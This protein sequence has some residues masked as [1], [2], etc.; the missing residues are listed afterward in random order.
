MQQHTSHPLFRTCAF[1][2]ACGLSVLVSERSRAAADPGD[3][4]GD[5]YGGVSLHADFAAAGLSSL[6]AG[7][8]EL[9]ADG[10]LSMNDLEIAGAGV[11]G[12]DFDPNRSGFDPDSKTLVRLYRWGGIR[13]IYRGNDQKLDID[14]SISNTSSKPLT[15]L[16]ITLMRLTFPAVPDG[17][18]WTNGY[19]ISCDRS[20][21]IPVLLADWHSARLA[22]CCSDPN[23][24]AKFGFKPQGGKPGDKPY[25]LWVK[26]DGAPIGP[27]ATGETKISLRIGGAAVAGENAFDIARDVLR[28]YAEKYHLE[29]AWNDR[30]P[31]GSAFLA[32]SQKDYPKNPRGW[33]LDPDID[34]TTPE[35]RAQFKIKMLAYAD[36]V[37]AH[38]KMMD[39]Q[40]VIVWDLEGQEMPHAT[41]Y[42]A[43]PRMLAKVAPEMDEI[44][45]E[46]MKKFSD[47]GL[48]TGLTIRPT[49]VA[50]ADQGRPGWMQ[51]D[52]SDQ[53]AEID[54]K[55]TYA[56]KRWGCTLFYLDS[57]V[58][59]VK[60]STGK[61]LSDPAMPAADFQKLARL[62]EDC[63]LMPEH[64]VG[65]YW[66]YTAPY[67]EF[68]LGFAS[69]PPG[70]R[71]AYPHAF[72]VLRVVDGPSLSDPDSISKL[73]AAVK[74][75]D[76]LLFRP[77]WDDPQTTDI[78][79]IYDVT[80]NEPRS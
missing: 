49:R 9:L 30:R 6:K 55:L 2:L 56:Q 66:A 44:A 27:G 74:A 65:R 21:D 59:F 71:E 22:M 57:N 42:L 19:M 46:F 64:H 8:T 25:D 50:A 32:T 69:T 62:H 31:I 26:F 12:A 68:R 51:Q 58:D 60:D 40:G 29:L 33:L 39:A 41:S 38:C 16:G 78:K 34:T 14:L 45:D 76:I 18:D 28:G 53:T 75:G 7:D 5:T 47:A 43:D 63:L 11:N 24:F 1:V 77:W 15:R 80:A 17:V 3:A 48:R 70:V 79:H 61:V 23:E 36:A 72:S 67:S 37:I 52:V 20:D 35:G 13:A 10:N 54:Q 73:S 4:S